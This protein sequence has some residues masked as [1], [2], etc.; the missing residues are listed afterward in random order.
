MHNY[1]KNNYSSPDMIELLKQTFIKKKFPITSA[2]SAPSIKYW[3]S[4]VYKYSKNLQLYPIKTKV[5]WKL[6]SF[7][8]NSFFF[9]NDKDKILGK[10]IRKFHNN[11]SVSKPLVKH[12]NNKTI[13]LIF[14]Y[15]LK[16]N[17]LTSLFYLGR[18]HRFYGKAKYHKYKKNRLLKIEG[19]SFRKHANKAYRYMILKLCLDIIFIRHSSKHSK[20]YKLRR[21]YWKY[22]R[23]AWNWRY[24]INMFL[25][26]F[27]FS[28]FRK[29]IYFRNKDKIFKYI[30]ENSME[31]MEYFILK[32]KW[33]FFKLEFL[34]PYVFKKRGHW[35][36]I[37][38]EKKKRYW[39]LRGIWLDWRN[40]NRNFNN[41]SNKN[42]NI[43]I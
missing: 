42:E 16:K 32:W 38:A 27:I 12:S 17:P 1:K 15:N 8:L 3:D 24:N 13:I 39:R 36:N 26:R 2:Y 6:L 4:S 19:K 40:L 28:I 41:F 30:Q 23:Y 22:L 7:Y 18:F 5:V 37:S 11:N 35:L 31:R 14:I 20:F 25:F 9:I 43:N 33:N 10:T 34:I 21:R 29:H